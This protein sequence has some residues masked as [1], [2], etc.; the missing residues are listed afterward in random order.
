MSL[1]IDNL[2]FFYDRRK[3]LSNLS[4]CTAA[5]RITALLGP[6]AAGKSTLLRCIVG[7]LR[8]TR[9][10][11]T[12]D[13]IAS[14]RMRVRDLAT[15]LAYVPQRSVVSAAFTVREIIELGRYALPPDASKVDHAIERLDLDDL[16]DR[17]YPELSVGQ[18]QRVMLARALA[19]LSPTGY[20]LL[21]E[22]LSAMDLRYVQHALVLLRELAQGGASVLIAMH[23]ISLAAALADEVWLLNGGSLVA[24]GEVAK[25]LS[26]DRLR[27]VFGVDFQWVGAERGRPSLLAAVHVAGDHVDPFRRLDRRVGCERSHGEDSTA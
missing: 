27:A 23:D 26:L 19:Q 13:G 4:V 21:D 17:P 24:S 18:Q 15:R 22:P 25:V 14:H 11:V 9:G 10:A 6:N 3:V 16:A 20:L 7:S 1:V 2:H 12:I 5:G 8:P